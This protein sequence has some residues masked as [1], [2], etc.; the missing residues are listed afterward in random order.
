MYEAKKSF[1]ASGSVIG[2]MLT[3]IFCEQWQGCEQLLII[4]FL[5]DVMNFLHIQQL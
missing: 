1:E 3:A 4:T 5:L 2:H